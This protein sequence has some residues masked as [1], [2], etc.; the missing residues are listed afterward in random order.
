MVFNRVANRVF[1][2]A[3]AGLFVLKLFFIQMFTSSFFSSEVYAGIV[4]ALVKDA[5]ENKIKALGYF[6][7]VSQRQVAHDQLVIKKYTGDDSA[8]ECLDSLG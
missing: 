5:A 7:Q 8:R 4:D 1:M 2:P 3:V 6:P